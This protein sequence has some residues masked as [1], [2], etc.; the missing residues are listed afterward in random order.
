MYITINTFVSIID[1][2]LNPRIFVNIYLS[3]DICYCYC[4]VDEKT[5][6]W[7]LRTP[8]DSEYG[9]Y[10]HVPFNSSDPELS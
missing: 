9:N 1:V 4:F 5:S 6:T 8:T 2:L 3:E 7:T 10:V